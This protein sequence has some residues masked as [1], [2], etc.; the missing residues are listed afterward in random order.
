MFSRNKYISLY[1]K[2]KDHNPHMNMTIP[3]HLHV[4]M[5]SSNQAAL[6]LF[7]DDLCIVMMVAKVDLICVID[8][9]RILALRM[10]ERH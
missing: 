7:Q 1:R 9:S 2:D 10:T 3:R 8:D 4:A 5:E 6:Q